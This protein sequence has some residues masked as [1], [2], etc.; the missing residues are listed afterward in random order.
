MQRLCV[1]VGGLSSVP[2][3][4]IHFIILRFL[5]A[6]PCWVWRWLLHLQGTAFYLRVPWGSASWIDYRDAEEQEVHAQDT[7]QRSVY[8]RTDVHTQ[9]RCRPNTTNASTKSSLNKHCVTFSSSTQCT[10]PSCNPMI[11][12]DYR[13][14]WHISARCSTLKSRATSIQCGAKTF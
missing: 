6:N 11:P 12:C 7:K 13:T 1:C 8:S 9:C 4:Q 10:L 14:F 2:C 5:W 3:L